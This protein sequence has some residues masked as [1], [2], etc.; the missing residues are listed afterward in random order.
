LQRAI[1]DF[2]ADDPFARVALKLREHYGFAIGES[3]IQRIALG[4]AR[5]IFESSGSSPDFPDEPSQHK[6]IVAQIDGGMVPVVQPDADRKDKRKGKKLS[7]REAKIS[8]A[9]AK[10]SRTP[11]YGG[12]I[13]GGVKEAGRRLR[14]PCGLRGGFAR[15]CGRGWRAVDRRPDRRTVRCSG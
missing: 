15:A 2:A 4:H 11:V 13:E 6:Q 14:G 12:G 1:V 9:H 8:L 5:A 10:G 7:W 3:T